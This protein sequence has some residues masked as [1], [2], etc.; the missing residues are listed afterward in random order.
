MKYQQIKID[1]LK[2]YKNNARK[3]SKDQLKKIAASI[4]EFGFVNPVLVDGKNTIIAGH[5]RVEAAKTLGIE[6]VP[7]VLV[8][9]LS[10]SQKRAYIIADNRLAELSEWD[11]EL[12]N[13]EL[14]E[15]KQ[16]D[17]KLDLT[18]FDAIPK[19]EGPDAGNIYTNKIQIPLYEIKGEKPSEAN[20]YDTNKYDELVGEIEV[21]DAPKKV[22]DFLKHAAARHTV[23]S[24]DKIA[25]YYAHAPKNVQKLMEKSALVIIDYKAAI[26]NGFVQLSNDLAEAYKN[27][28]D[29]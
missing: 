2:P 10:E 13:L 15:L 29:A 3:H 8:E 21:M 1:E 7:C 5:G 9:H 4:K 23:F 22:K 17:F 27:E 19:L 24:Y 18:G 20:L 14:N 11:M 25:E 6:A 12:L 26:E 28:L 16:L